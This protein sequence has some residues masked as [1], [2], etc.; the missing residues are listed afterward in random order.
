MLVAG[1]KLGGLVLLEP[2]GAKGALSWWMARSA[3]GDQVLVAI[4]ALKNPGRATRVRDRLRIAF[5]LARGLAHPNLLR[6]LDAGVEGEHHYVVSEYAEG[7]LLSQLLERSAGAPVPPFQAAWIVAE[8]AR[9]LAYLEANAGSLATSELTPSS[10]LLTKSGAVKL[11]ELVTAVETQDLVPTVGLSSSGAAGYLAPEVAESGSKDPRSVLFA[12]GAIFWELLSGKPL[13]RRSTELETLAAV[14]TAD[15]PPLPPHLPPP[16]LRIVSRC[17]SRAPSE[18]YPSAATLGEELEAALFGKTGIGAVELAAKLAPLLAEPAPK[19]RTAVLSDSEQ[20]GRPVVRHEKT[21]PS[22]PP[23]LVAV[24]A[25]VNRTEPSDPPS[26]AIRAG[27]AMRVTKPSDP[28]FDPARDAGAI[29]NP[30]FQV[31]GRL[32][33][34]GMGEVYRV[35]DQE[36]NEVVALKVIPRNTGNDAQSLERLRREV[37]LARRISSDHVCRIFDIV[38][39][40]NGG[41]GLTMAL[42]RGVTLAELMK[43]GLTTDYRRYAR[44]GAEIAD[45]LA[46]AHGISIVHRDLKPEN[47]MIREDDQAVVLDFGIAR[48]AA[49]APEP[50]DGKLTQQGI[51]MGTPLYMSPEQLTNRPLDGRSDLY[52]LGLIM[53]ELITGEVP[54]RGEGYS[55]I[56]EERVL[57]ATP[58]AIREVDGRVPEELAEVVDALLKPAAQ[59]RPPTATHVSQLLFRAAGSGKSGPVVA[60]E[61]VPKGVATPDRAQPRSGSQRPLPRTASRRPRPRPYGLYAGVGLVVTACL[62]AAGYWWIGHPGPT[63]IASIPPDP[64]VVTPPRLA[65]DAGPSDTNAAE[66]TARGAVDDLGLEFDGGGTAPDAGKKKPYVPPVE[67]M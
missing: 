45:G 35:H 1:G 3:D 47:I 16:L 26:I 36:L 28:F 39:L 5:E 42:V 38:D 6:V 48:T 31:L 22:E 53:A 51:I 56:L 27:E 41:R 2:R 54:L 32:G 25:G 21:V 65:A 58:Y 15:I 14:R 50:V 19:R 64:A 8:V 61:S 55:Q 57:K 49:D 23:I 20:S 7:L 40:G 13:F 43:S 44:W 30:R 24:Q 29:V 12:L 67:E 46:A 33:A 18:R 52:A 63:P 62:G 60:G 11:A 4:G 10:V 66:A 34:G 59:D 37:R 17:L 9:A